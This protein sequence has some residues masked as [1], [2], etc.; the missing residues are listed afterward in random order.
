M[1]VLIIAPNV[2][3]TDVGEAFVAFKWVEALS[4]IAN[5][6]VLAFQRA[7]RPDLAGQLPHARVVTWPEPS[8]ARQ[9][10]RLNAMLKPAWPVFSTHVRKWMKS[11]VLAGED[12]DI[13]HQLMPQAA[14]YPSPLRHFE[15][16][17]IIGPL[18]GAM[19]TPETFRDEAANAPL[20]TRL[21]ALDQYRFRYDPLLRKSY[22]R[23]ACILGVAPYV[24]DILADIPL[25]RFEPVLEL[26]VDDVEQAR[27]RTGQKDQLRVLHVGRG[28]RTKGLRDTVR[29]MAG[30]K[31]LQ[32]VTLTSAGSGEE[33]EICRAEAKRLGVADRVTFRG[34]ISRE[35]V[36]QL[37]S[38][39]DVFCFPSFREPAGG[40]LYEA[41]RHGLPVIAADRGGPASIIDASSGVR[42]P[43]T[44]PVQ[45]AQ[46]ISAA[47]R[48]FAQ[49]P[50]LRTRLGE[51]ARAKVLDEGLWSAK[52][53]GLISLYKD[54][55]EC[56]SVP[57]PTRKV[58]TATPIEC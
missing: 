25:R 5:V 26:G 34:K 39:H 49:S 53:D 45:F 29:A 1:K 41:M 35:E 46:D 4:R 44:E 56:P 24:E 16:P 6:T 32:G 48:Q 21:R 43:V 17:Y 50:A 15:V 55:L 19:D 12:F 7:G 28:V 2:D 30:L 8:W 23:A 11:A 20:F 54:I 57:T 40:V 37:Y 33:I 22:S 10:E 36:E 13:A 18:G 52:A 47:L 3:A 31:D 38:S 51:G 58:S 9:N 27:H 42:I 14:R